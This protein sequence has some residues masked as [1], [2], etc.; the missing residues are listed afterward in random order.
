MEKSTTTIKTESMKLISFNSPQMRASSTHLP[1][2]DRGKYFDKKSFNFKSFR[3]ELRRFFRHKKKIFNT[4]KSNRIPRPFMERIM[5]AITAVNKCRYCSWLHTRMALENGSTVEELCNLM[6]F[7]FDG[8]CEDEIVA[9][10]FCQH[11]AESDRHPSRE[12]IRRLIKHYGTQKARDIYHIISM[13]YF[14]N[15]IGNTADAFESRIYGKPAKNGSPLLEF[16]VYFL[17]GFLLKRYLEWTDKRHQ[18][19]N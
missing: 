13:I 11:Y 1:L 19:N 6:E 10:T 7:E 16:L 14:G 9:L 3:F 8:F 4:M 5:V 2:K 12:S 18:K 17:G 15:L